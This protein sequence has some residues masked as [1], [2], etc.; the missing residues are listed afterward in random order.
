MKTFKNL[1]IKQKMTFVL[2]STPLILSILL[3]YFSAEK[4]VEGY[5][6]PKS[7][8]AVRTSDAILDKIDR[9]FHERFGDV[10][11][12]AYNKL[13]ISLL[14]SNDQ[15][16]VVET[17]ND[18]QKFINTMTKYYVLYD[19]MM[20]VDLKGNVVISNNI[21]K[22]GNK[23][24][25]SNLKFENFENSEWFK[26]CTVGS[27]PEGGAWYSDFSRN[28][29]VAR[30]YKSK[31]YGMGFAA[32]IKNEFGKIIGVWYNYANW[33]EVTQG[34]RKQ[35]FDLLKKEEPNALILITDK[36]N[37]VIDADDENLIDKNLIINVS[38]LNA[39]E[40]TIYSS[41]LEFKSKEYINGWS[42]AKGA[43]LYKGKNWKA[44]TMIPK[45][46]LTIGTLFSKDL[47][48]L[49]ILV[50]TLLVISIIAS[51]YFIKN[52][53]GKIEN[54]N[55]ILVRMS[56]GDLAQ[57]DTAITSNDELGNVI[58]SLDEVI[59]FNE[60][61][62]KLKKQAE[63][64]IRVENQKVVDAVNREM[65]AR[66]KLMDELC[67]VS[68][69]DL[70]GF[71]TY[72]N[73]KHCE[74]S[75]YTREELI[76]SNQN[77]VR[78]PDMSKEVFKELWSTIGRGQIFRGPV[79]NRKKDGTPYYVDGVFA[80][81]LGENGKPIKYIGVRYENTLQTFEKQAAEG[82]V[83]AINTSFAFIEFDTKGNI[84]TANEIFQNTMGY[85]L[86]EIVGRHHSMFVEPAFA[87]TNQYSRL[88]E[89][90]A[91][92]IPQSGLNKRIAKNGNEVWLQSVYSPVKDEM[93]RVIKVIKI[94]TDV[95]A[96]T[97]AAVATQKATNEVMRV[98]DALSVGD[99]TQKYSIL[100]EAELKQMGD[101]L[102]ATIEVL[103]T[104]K[105]GEIE[106]QKAAEEVSRVIKA[107]AEGDLTQRYSINS[108]GEL[109]LMGDALNKTIEVLNSLLSR[110]MENSMNISAASIEMANSAQQLSEGA[111]NQ[112]SSVEEISSSM[113]QMTA[114][115]QQNTSNSRQTEKIA[116]KAAF[117]IL[118]SKE[119]VNQ[120]ESS[121]K[122]IASK[123]SIIGEISRQTNLLALNA[124]VEAARAGEHGRGFAVVAAEVRK[125]AERSQMAATEIDEVSAKS[126][127]VAQKSGQMLNDV[128]PNIQKTADLVME[129]TASSNEQSSGS[130]QINNAIQN[131]NLVVQEN[132]A[133]AEEMA[134]GAEELS[135]QAENLQD[136]ISFFK[137]EGMQQATLKPK[138]PSEN[139]K[140][141][142]AT[143]RNFQEFNPK[144]KSSSGIDIHLGED[145]S[146]DNEFIDF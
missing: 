121:M 20:I 93:G 50:L 107:L 22:S 18:A 6:K 62:A 39:V 130:E 128:V 104:Q 73:D 23:I 83:N 129:I 26:T 25:V 15:K 37:R 114:N 123:I 38:K 120:T 19:L 59:K 126:V 122:L 21:D 87:N 24:D 30:I 82:V 94:A 113:Q 132:A 118:E 111:T 63:D 88:W 41:G 108:T 12:F 67:I 72:V 57:L 96:A 17:R 5:N 35:A 106:T 133:T 101:A 14:E 54:V 109:K 42:I 97:N 48:G 51:S 125:L 32:P 115:I 146:L 80:P 137:I 119:S 53:I 78:H 134:A 56:K 98:L 40:E 49:V 36:Q 75:Q 7:E 138:T 4:V 3:T 71:I 131:L 89:N 69:T 145:D 29:H 100:S 136:A 16:N 33:A 144:S 124:A 140:K 141:K 92:G 66:I 90:L 65:E 142:P 99:L 8:I 81:V 79:K 112:A 46:N 31:G 70:R 95:T 86:E 102:N 68:E 43:Y 1:T 61:Q 52:I 139:Q 127:F 10:Q 110:V 44:V 143:S 60:L 91:S 2:L 55:S 103:I 27:G 74:V 28:E 76:G 84:L 45:M 9:N 77:M 105:E 11:A 85:N 64:K 117:D 47:I 58:K 34:I 135:A 116:S 13:A